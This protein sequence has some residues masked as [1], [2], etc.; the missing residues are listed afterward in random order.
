MKRK[1]LLLC[2]L[3]GSYLLNAQ[4]LEVESVVDLETNL[5]E[6]SGLIMLNN[7]L[8]THN[9]SG[10][11]AELYE[12]DTL[13]GNVSRTVVIKN[14]VNTDWEDI[15]KDDAF[16]YIGD[17]G[18]NAGIRTDL[19]VLRVSISEYTT[20]LNDTVT[21]DTI[22]FNFGDQTT[23]TP[24]LY[25][26]NFDVEGMLA[27][28]DSLYIFTKNWGDSHTSYYALSKIPG[29][30]TVFPKGILN[31]EGMITG[32]T[33]NEL[34]NEIMLCGYTFSSPFILRI[35]QFSGDDFENGIATRYQLDVGTS[36]IQIEGVCAYS[37]EGYYFSS[38][39]FQ[40]KSAQVSRLGKANDLGIQP[41]DQSEGHIYPNPSNETISIITPNFF[42]V[43]IYDLSNQLI[44]QAQQKEIN[45][46]ALSSGLYLVVMYDENG[47][48]IES[49]KFKKN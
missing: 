48:V 28:G 15:C 19:Y 23:F 30:F 45:I 21:A 39:Y 34:S 38:E 35:D 1:V 43:E 6:T 22:H 4:Q 18:N 13:T 16:I 32:A 10:T 27:M 17:F 2:I 31:S 47:E 46:S 29:N 8:V 3:C 37:S 20:A 33:Y 42:K 36:S 14:A 26:T 25:T 12:V 49:S 5:V 7:K 41:Y 40:G 11:A 44:L 24:Q 9:D